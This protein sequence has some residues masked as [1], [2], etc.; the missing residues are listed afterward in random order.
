MK[1]SHGRI[2]IDLAKHHGQ[3][4]IFNMLKGTKDFNIMKE[5]MKEHDTNIKKQKMWE[6]IIHQ[7][8]VERGV[9]AKHA[10][11]METSVTNTVPLWVRDREVAFDHLSIGVA[12]HVTCV[13]KMKAD[14]ARVAVREKGEVTLPRNFLKEYG[15]IKHAHGRMVL[16]REWCIEGV[17]KSKQTS[18]Y[19]PAIAATVAQ[20]ARSDVTGESPGVTS[21]LPP[22]SPRRSLSTSSTFTSRSSS[23]AS[24]QLI[25]PKP[26]GLRAVPEQDESTS[27]AVEIKLADSKKIIFGKEPEQK[28]FRGV[29]D[30][31]YMSSDALLK[32]RQRRKTGDDDGPLE[33]EEKT[34][35]KICKNSL[36]KAR[37]MHGE[38][39]NILKTIKTA[40]CIAGRAIREQREAE[41]KKS[42]RGK[43]SS[44]AHL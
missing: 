5:R 34:M 21:I 29:R 33:L 40:T 39:G 30:T 27:T 20:A 13:L 15:I 38:K 1:D 11:F 32:K 18:K 28:K 42:Q 16:G 17:T 2:I 41:L 6:G 23:K 37:T 26:L 31:T 24:R 10:K 4:E 35:R 22:L 19:R 36:G 25:T 14:K 43:P 12:T 7:G 44:T 8:E 3:T 9:K